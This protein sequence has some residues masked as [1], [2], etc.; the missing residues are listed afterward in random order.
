MEKINGK[1][2]QRIEDFYVEEIPMDIKEDK[3]G[4]YSIFILEKFNW[5]TTQAILR[6]AKALKVS[7]KRFGI[8]GTKDKR[9]VTKQFVS[10]WKVSKEQLENLKLKDMKITFYKQSS[11]RLNLGMIKGNKFIIT[12]R[13]IKDEKN[14]LERKLISIFKNL[15]KGIP[16][17]FGPQRFGEVRP[18]TAEVGKAMLKSD[19]ENAVKIYLTKVFENEPEDAKKARNWLAKNWEQKNFSDSLKL[20]PKRLKWERSM[21]DYLMKNKNDFAGALRRIP[22]RLRKIFINAVQSEIWNNVVS[23]IWKN[24]KINDKLPLPGYNTILNKDNL[25]HYELIK[26]LEKNNIKLEDFKMKSMPELACTG[27]ERNILLIPK[28]LKIIEISEDEINKGKLK[29]KISFI[30][31][32]GSYASVVL[33]YIIS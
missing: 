1:L 4:E 27:S 26:E 11:E 28:E 17:F 30:L 8:A 14:E 18:I 12:I 6:I 15:E 21:L 33:S 16:N 25:F 29:A 10:V 19:F 22:K 3:N 9:A 32:P 5:E 2:R 7:K 23:R 24:A 31:P 20:F 13:D